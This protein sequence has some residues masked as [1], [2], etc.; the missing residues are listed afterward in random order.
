MRHRSL[1]VFACAVAISATSC[2]PAST[3]TPSLASTRPAPATPRALTT[4]SPVTPAAFLLPGAAATLPD[5]PPGVPFTGHLLIAENSSQNRILEIDPTGAVTWTFATTSPPLHHPLGP[6]DDTFYSANGSSILM[7]S[8][9]GQGVLDIART[10]GTVLWQLGAY[11]HRGDTSNLFS[12]P[13]DA[14]PAA[15][16][17]VWLADIRNCRVLH[18]NS[19]GAVMSILGGHG[20]RHNPPQQFSEPNG[21]FPTAD[22]SLVVTEISGDWVTWINPDGS[23]RWS[24][25]A[26][27]VYPSDAL[28][29]S[30]GSVLLTDYT[31]PGSVLHIAPDGTVLWRY[32]PRGMNQLN[33]PSIAIPIA[34]NRVAVVDDLNNRIE[35]I[36]PTTS[37]VVWQWSG[38]GAYHLVH[39]DGIDYRPS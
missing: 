7:S 27:T 26:P 30:D 16:G 28:G 21:A 33:H 25:K 4:T 1:V 39:P 24:H 11:L 15:D 17:T 36:D 12:N 20:C 2:S 34:S 22:G 6:P 37:A 35:I 18:I 13:D 10:S 9:T 38:S 5:V 29:Y 8:E 32:S 3:H 14:V 23:V 19:T 31:S